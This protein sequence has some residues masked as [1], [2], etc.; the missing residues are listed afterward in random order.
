MEFSADAC[1]EMKAVEGIKSV[2]LPAFLPRLPHLPQVEWLHLQLTLYFQDPLPYLSSFVP[3]WQ[4]ALPSPVLLEQ[5]LES[6][7][8]SDI[9]RIDYRGSQAHVDWES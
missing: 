2:I 1:T 9:W 3:D 4:S 7:S 6:Q 5:P 8:L